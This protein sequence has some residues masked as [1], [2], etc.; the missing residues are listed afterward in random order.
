MDPATLR[1]LIREVIAEEVAA[2]RA[3][4]PI[5]A[6]ASSTSAPP[7]VRIANDADLA[8]FARQVLLLAEQP[9]VRAAILAGRH[10]FT[11]AGAAPAAASTGAAPSPS[12]GT[13][14]STTHRGDT[15][16]IDQG[17]VT[18]SLV[19][20][21]PAGISRLLLGPG[22][23]LTPLARDKAKAR[24]LSIERTGP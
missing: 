24:H 11:L 20:K 1:R 6:P 12:G 16:R 7:P 17:V 9:M 15:H 2:L 21:L 14:G 13:H 10:H 8:A 5:S 23:S 18:E 22:V 4:R 19:G 3:A